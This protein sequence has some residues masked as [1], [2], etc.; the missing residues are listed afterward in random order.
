MS[1]NP[2]ARPHW[3]R[4]LAAVCAFGL[5]AAACGDDGGEPI[6]NPDDADSGDEGDGGGD[7]GTPTPGGTITF[8]LESAVDSVDPANDLAQPA[9]KIVALAIYDPLMSFDEEG[10]VVPYLAESV[11]S[12]E[13]LTVWTVKVPTGILFHDGTPFNAEAVKLQ[14]DRFLD[15]ATNCTCLPDLTQ[16]TSIEAPDDTTVIFTLAEPNVAFTVQLSNSRGYIASPTAVAAL[17]N[18]GFDRA[19]VGTGPFRMADYDN[20]VV[21]KNPDY[22]RT[23]DDGTQLPYLDSIDFEEIPDST[24]RLQAVQAGDIDIMQTADTANIVDAKAAGLEVQEITGSS[25]T[26]VFFNTTQPPFDDVRARRAVAFALNRERANEIIYEGARTE[27]Y[28][29]FPPGY[30]Y[31]VELDEPLPRYDVDEARALVDEYE[32][33]NGP[34]AFSIICI[35]TPE[36]EQLLQ[37]FQQDMQEAGMDVTLDTLDQGEYVPL[38]FGK[39]PSIQAGCFRNNQLSD[40]DQIYSGLIT[41]GGSNIMQYSNPVVDEALNAGRATDDVEARKEAYRTVLQETAND[42]PTIPTL[43]DLFGNIHRPELHGLPAPEANALGA[44]KSATI[45]LEQ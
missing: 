35:P 40:P 41:G 33:E 3:W 6:A 25:S 22:W 17:G 19:P 31:E 12:N 23:G 20:L 9:D 27:S 44:I 2:T 13:D 24:T 7:E 21:E 8:G 42:V 11:E 5:L 26:I 43:F 32:A 14:Y 38:V 36:A 34:L 15:P 4:L 16:I 28:S 10:N 1:K 39:D 37:L 30:L 45:W 29:A 18:D